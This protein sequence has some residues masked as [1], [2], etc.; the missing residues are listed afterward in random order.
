MGILHCFGPVI[1]FIKINI[2]DLS[3]KKL[4]PDKNVMHP[5]KETKKKPVLQSCFYDVQFGD[6]GSDDGGNFDKKED[7]CQRSQWHFWF[8]VYIT[9]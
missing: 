8:E 6:I 2:I 3:H 9:I 5:E 4:Q 7:F 1:A